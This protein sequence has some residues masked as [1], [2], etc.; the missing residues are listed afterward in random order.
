MTG[1]SGVLESHGFISKWGNVGGLDGEIDGLALD[2]SIFFDLNE[3][4]P[5]LFGSIEEI[6]NRKK[7]KQKTDK[8]ELEIWDGEM[9]RTKPKKDWK[10]SRSS[11][12]GFL[13]PKK[14][15]TWRQIALPLSTPGKK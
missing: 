14:M 1:F 8:P 5:D 2:F 6:L 4:N 13:A 7:N 11:I 12:L 3:S 15:W 10:Q 9:Y